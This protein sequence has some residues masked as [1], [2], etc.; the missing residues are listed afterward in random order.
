MILRF[1][2][3]T[4]NLLIVPAVFI[5]TI[6]LSASHEGPDMP[7]SELCN[8]HKSL[9]E[10]SEMG[11]SSVENVSICHPSPHKKHSAIWDVKRDMCS[12]VQDRHGLPIVFTKNVIFLGGLRGCNLNLS[13]WADGFPNKSGGI[14]FLKSGVIR[15]I[16]EYRHSDMIDR[17]QSWCRSEIF[18][19]RRKLPVMF[20]LFTPTLVA[21]SA[22]NAFEGHECSLGGL[23]RFAA[24]F[25]G[26]G[27]PFDS[28]DPK[29]LWFSGW[30]SYSPSTI[31][32]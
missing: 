5:R 24:D 18:E 28:G 27:Y 15:L 32:L 23:Q 12:F 17:T 31:D 22:D 10:F 11:F 7:I 14:D 21:P 2:E 16:C 20:A 29:G 9:A 8:A 3:S 19:L 25:I 30:R 4:N 6:V 1:I 26:D 13:P